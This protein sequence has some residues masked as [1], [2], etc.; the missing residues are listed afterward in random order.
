MKKIAL[1]SIAALALL[2]CQKEVEVTVEESVPTYSATI[3]AGIGD[4]DTKTSYTDEGKFSW[5]KGDRI[6]VQVITEQ[7][8]RVVPF[9][10]EDSKP[11]ATFTGEIPEGFVKGAM[12]AYPHQ[13]GIPDNDVCN[14]DLVFHSDVNGWELS[15]N[16]KPSLEKPLASLPL[17]GQKDMYDFYQFKTAT[18]IVKFTIVNV[19]S[20]TL[21]A[22]LK[23]V[24]GAKLAGIF[25]AEDC[26]L[27]MKNAIEAGNVIR[28][29]NAPKDK[30]TT[31][32]YYFFVPVGKLVAGTQF[33]LYS[34][35]EAGAEPIYTIDFKKDVDIAVNRVTNI[36][37]ILMP[38]EPSRKRDS[39]ALVAVY[40]AAD[41]ANWKESRRWDLKLT[42][43]KWPGIK[44]NEDGRVIELSI[45]NGTVTSVDWE[46][47]VEIA[48]L[49]ELATFQ[50]VGSRV[51]GTFP[52]FLYGMTKL[53]VLRLNSNPKLTGSLSSKI[54]QLTELKELFINGTGIS[55]TIPAQIGQLKKLNNFNFAQSGISGALP[56][57]IALCEGLVT[58]VGYES[59]LTSI[60]DNFDQWPAVKTF[61]LY[62]CKNLECPLPASLGNNKTVTSIQLK[63]GNFTGSIPASY[64]NLPSTCNQLFLNGN[65]LHGLVPASV[66]AH[67]KWL[68]DSG[69]KYTVNILPQQ[70]G[71]NLYLE[72]NRQ[73]DSLALVKIYN[74]ADGANWKEERRWTLSKPINEWD[75]ITVA[76]DRVTKLQITAQG[77]I[78]SD[79]ELPAEIGDLSELTILKLNQCK[80]SGTLPEE[81]YNLTNLTELWLQNGNLTGSLSPKLGQLNKLSK[82]YIDRQGLSGPLPA[83]IG[84]LT[85]LTML[86][87]SKT[88]ISGAFP[89]EFTS[90][91]K[92]TT[93]MAY[94]TKMTDLPD[95]WDQL[96]ELKIIQLYGNEV[97]TG[98]LP[99][100][101]SK[102][103]KV[104]SIQIKQCNF[105]G[106][107]PAS[108]GNLPSTCNQL[109][110]NGNKLEGVV[111]AAVQAHPKWLADSGWKY[112]DNIL[113][114]QEGYELKLTE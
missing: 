87:I 49:T 9:T 73:T 42:M 12:A 107:I 71:Y 32:D 36:K 48:D 61:M 3:K 35:A 27:Y 85:E 103:K 11:I 16:T 99:E 38:E 22:E 95:Y 5:V 58:F 51:I 29:H 57:E 105:T 86:N 24:E 59:Q 91:K 8:T 82:V 77:V 84:Q 112:T 100:S 72:L 97:Y 113:P 34:S 111:P 79:W 96:P 21:L 15:A 46:L 60:P 90:C 104:T 17:L 102:L 109:F 28:N 106:N 31:M 62:G 13:G 63:N 39:L 88:Q 18:G 43:D 80:L 69:W 89:Q 68:A 94:D 20:A 66:Q 47:P 81:L 6:S 74:A 10:T 55:G 4:V 2:A 56:E 75:G 101:F 45:T 110:L 44:L 114:Q 37:E 83:E 78:N 25:E 93:L 26:V 98:P 41:G 7:V 53:T 92:M 30:N 108:Y 70:E 50:A 23:G 76:N 19:P 67:P 65:K 40:N 52:E 64:G 54:A 1:F 33:N 14:N